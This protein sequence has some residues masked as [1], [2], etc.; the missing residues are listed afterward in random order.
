MINK[1][2]RFGPKIINDLI[3]IDVG[4]EKAISLDY[5]EINGDTLVDVIEWE[6]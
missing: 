4:M 2:F 1:E 3:F 5:F 6:Q